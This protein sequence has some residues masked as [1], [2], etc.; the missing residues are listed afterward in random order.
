MQEE[1]IDRPP[2]PRPRQISDQALPCRV[3]HLFG[4]V[5]QTGVQGPGWLGPYMDVGRSSSPI[6]ASGNRWVLRP[7][8]DPDRIG[9]REEATFPP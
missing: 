5:R 2:R 4:T 3:A 1:G 8:D 9:V 7:V 6:P